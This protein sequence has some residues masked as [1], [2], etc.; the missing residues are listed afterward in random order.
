VC[1]LALDALWINFVAGPLF[2]QAVGPLMAPSL[3]AWAAASFYLAYP[4]GVVHFAV[5]PQGNF[6]GMRRAAGAGALFGLFAYG[7]YDLTNLA[8]LRDWPVHLALIDMAWG[9]TVS[10]IGAMAGKA[11]LDRLRAG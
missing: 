3:N 1:L 2:A 6:T 10:A 5:M 4:L 7:T 9:A 11:A 8:T